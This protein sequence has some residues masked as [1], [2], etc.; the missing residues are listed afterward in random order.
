MWANKFQIAAIL[1]NHLKQPLPIPTVYNDREYSAES[2]VL[3]TTNLDGVGQTLHSTECDRIHI[4]TLWTERNTLSTGNTVLNQYVHLILSQPILDIFA[5]GLV[6]TYIYMEVI[7]NSDFV[8][9]RY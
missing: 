6:W 1:L 9:I 2:K 7:S 5:H 8:P 3:F 4:H